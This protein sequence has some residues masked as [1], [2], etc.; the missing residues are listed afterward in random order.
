MTPSPLPPFTW[1]DS[2]EPNQHD[3]FL[4]HLNQ[5]DEISVEPVPGP[6]DLCPES[7]SP[8]LEVRRVTEA[9]CEDPLAS[10]CRRIGFILHCSH[11]LAT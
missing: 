8:T 10:Q 9:W 2:Q 6:T 4:S 7:S 3:R 5:A 1:D 11:Y